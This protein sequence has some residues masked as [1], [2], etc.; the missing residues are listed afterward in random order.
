[1]VGLH[2]AVVAALY[3]EYG[4]PIIV[5]DHVNLLIRTVE[6][7]VVNIGGDQT[8][9]Q[10]VQRDDMTTCVAREARARARRVPLTV[11]RH[12]PEKCAAVFRKDHAQTTP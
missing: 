4:P 6:I 3:S 9:T 8:H 2:A 7:R 5:H 1:L 12:D 11:L 10:S